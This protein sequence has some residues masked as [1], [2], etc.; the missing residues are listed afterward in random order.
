[1]DVIKEKFYI[2]HTQ[3]H[4]SVGFPIRAMTLAVKAEGDPSTLAAPIRRSVRSLDASLPVAEVRTMEEVVDAALSTPAF[5]G[6]L[7]AS[8]AGLALV[9]AAIGIYGVLSYA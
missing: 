8:F 1:T 2:P 3:W 5:T 7:L 4:E 6:L 9:L